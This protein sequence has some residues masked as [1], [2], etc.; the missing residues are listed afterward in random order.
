MQ[1]IENSQTMGSLYAYI[2]KFTRKD[3]FILQRFKMETM[4]KSRAL[5]RHIDGSNVKPLENNIVTY[6]IKFEV[7]TK[8]D[9]ILC[10]FKKKL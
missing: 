4:L 3:D 6:W 1:E 9:Y 10:P 5:W 8:K 7:V 2:N